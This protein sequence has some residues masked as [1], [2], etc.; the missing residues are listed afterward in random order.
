MCSEKK[1]YYE[2]LLKGEWSAIHIVEEK[3]YIC[4]VTLYP[5]QNIQKW[6]QQQK[7]ERNEALQIE[8]ECQTPAT[9]QIL[10]EMVV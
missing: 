3:D 7:T 4:W 10:K 9:Y 8:G 2:T 5:Q 1:F 6:K